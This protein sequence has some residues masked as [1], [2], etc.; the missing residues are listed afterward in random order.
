MYSMMNAFDDFLLDGR[1][2]FNF[3]LAGRVLPFE[4]HFSPFLS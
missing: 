1:W 3:L 4:A 2:S